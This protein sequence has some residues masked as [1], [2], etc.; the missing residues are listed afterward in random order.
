MKSIQG[1]LWWVLIVS[2]CLTG[3]ILLLVKELLG[4]MTKDI[5]EELKRSYESDSQKNLA[6][7][8]EDVYRELSRIDF[9]STPYFTN[10][11]IIVMSEIVSMVN[12][13]SP[14]QND[15]AKA[16]ILFRQE[17]LRQMIQEPNERY[18]KQLNAA[19]H[20]KFSALER[21]ATEQD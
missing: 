6:T 9:A 4:D 21:K 5:Y 2:G 19:S 11:L 14:D 16:M 18:A 15:S 1:Y 13:I 17:E 20:P 10:A 3:I 12:A 8:L 7:M